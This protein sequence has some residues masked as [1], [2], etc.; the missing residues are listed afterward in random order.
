MSSPRPVHTR[1]ARLEVASNS[2]PGEPAGGCLGLDIGDI[3]KRVAAAV[4]DLDKA[5]FA[6]LLGQVEKDPENHGFVDFILMLHVGSSSLP[7]RLPREWLEAWA[8]PL[9]AGCSAIG[10]HRCEACL[11]VL[12][13]SRLW[14]VCPACGGQNLSVRDI[15]GNEQQGWPLP[16][17]YQP[18]REATG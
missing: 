5:I 16:W 2:R 1:L 10:H 4:A 14:N 11:L 6:E 7:E 12:P 3:T 15:G 13:N 18:I 9:P 17:Q 8:T